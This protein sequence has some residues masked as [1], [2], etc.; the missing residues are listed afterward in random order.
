[1]GDI[2]KHKNKEVRFAIEYAI[3]NGWR[4][5]RARGKGQ[6]WGKLYCSLR[7]REGCRFTIYGT[8]AIPEAHAKDLRRTIDRCIHYNQR[9]V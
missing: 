5:E 2:P 6:V 1:M 8:P 9:S 4:L 3:S 7:S